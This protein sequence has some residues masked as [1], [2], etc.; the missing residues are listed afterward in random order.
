[1]AGDSTPVPIIKLTIRSR[2]IYTLQTLRASSWADILP[3]WE[4]NATMPPSRLL[5]VRSDSA[6]TTLTPTTTS[7]L[8]ALTILLCTGFGLV[9]VLLLLR[10]RRKARQ[11]P[12][13]PSN[14][15]SPHNGL[16]SPSN[17]SG[18]KISHHRRLTVSATPY[19]TRDLNVHC[20]KKV[21]ASPASSAPSS[22]VPEIR[23]T[24]PE[25]EDESGKRKSGRVVVVSIS[26]KGHVG[27][28]PYRDEHL[29][30]YG[31]DDAERFQSLDLDR[32][33]GLKEVT[34]D[35]KRP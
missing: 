2:L 3:A 14:A 18:K 28:E 7:L 35:S 32:L 29:P 23:I 11:C 21:L 16:C 17:P 9:A 12:Q 20:E 8:I 19:S 34:M 5:Y 15:R 27:L 6:S 13:L 30:P 33:G 1:M 4:I 26:E 25:E 22:P 24:F 31:H 10:S